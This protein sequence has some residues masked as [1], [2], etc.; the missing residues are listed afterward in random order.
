MAQV[1]GQ[2]LTAVTW[3]I[4][5]GDQANKMTWFETNANAG[6]TSTTEASQKLSCTLWDHSA[7]LVEW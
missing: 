7:E 5:T 2:T 3:T 1:P 4:P 6:Y